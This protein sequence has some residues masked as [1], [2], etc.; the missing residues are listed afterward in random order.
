MMC[1][2]CPYQ[3]KEEWEPVPI[4]HW[5]SRCPGDIPPCE[6]DEYEREANYPDPDDYRDDQ[7]DWDDGGDDGSW[8]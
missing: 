4:C 7:T 3:W 8:D 5:K 2:Q 1:H 6:E